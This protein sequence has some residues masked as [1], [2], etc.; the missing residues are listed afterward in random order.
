MADAFV[1]TWKLVDSKNFDDYMKSLGEQTVGAGFRVRRV[2]KT[3]PGAEFQ[4]ECPCTSGTLP[5]S[6]GRDYRGT[7]GGLGWSTPAPSPSVLE[8]GCHG[9]SLESYITG[10]VRGLGTEP[11]ETQR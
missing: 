7:D 9:P 5:A 6:P 2:P 8:G 11:G 3:G 1:G 4:L 10:R